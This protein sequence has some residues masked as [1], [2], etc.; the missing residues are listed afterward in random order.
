MNHRSTKIK[1]LIAED[2]IETRLGIALYLAST[3]EFEILPPSVTDLEKSKELPVDIPGNIKLIH[4]YK[5][6]VVVMDIKWGSDKQGWYAGIEAARQIREDLP[7]TRVI[8]Y[9]NF[10]DRERVVRAVLE[11]QVDGYIPKEGYPATKLP[12]AI[13][14]VFNDLPYFV[15]EVVQR[16]LSIISNPAGASLVGDRPGELLNETE[17]EVLK[18]I[19]RGESN[20]TIAGDIGYAEG[21]IKGIVRKIYINLGIHEE[22]PRGNVDLRVMAIL[23]G[24]ELGYLNF[25]DLVPRRFS[26]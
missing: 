24:L 20:S 23:K 7:T 6:D 1:V 10:V 13:R 5:P 25:S 17:L 21:A 15:P 22:Y 14:T 16:L 11:G 12:E 4:E 2:S 9:S 18:H 26:S 8:L 19:A 3:N